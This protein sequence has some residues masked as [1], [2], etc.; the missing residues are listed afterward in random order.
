MVCIPMFGIIPNGPN[1]SALLSPFSLL[2]PAKNPVGRSVV[3]LFAPLAIIG[4]VGSRVAKEWLI[5]RERAEQKA[6]SKTAERGPV[7]IIGGAGYVGC[8]LVR[9]LLEQ[10]L[11]V[12]VLD[13][14]V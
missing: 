14:A 11:R 3:F 9:R 5:G 10:G 4:L 7:L 8:W 13:N 12:R 1:C 2:L 6:K